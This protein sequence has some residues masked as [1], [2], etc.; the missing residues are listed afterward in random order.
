ME[1]PAVEIKL[2][3]VEKLVNEGGVSKRTVSKIESLCRSV[4]RL[5]T[6]SGDEFYEG[7]CSLAGSILEIIRAEKARG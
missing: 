3:K 2:S 4:K 1:D 7:R 6:S 5:T